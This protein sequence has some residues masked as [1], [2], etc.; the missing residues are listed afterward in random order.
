[1]YCTVLCWLGYDL[2]LELMMERTD[3]PG[4]PPTARTIMYEHCSVPC[5]HPDRFVPNYL[6]SVS[7]N[8]LLCDADS[9]PRV[10]SPA[11]PGSQGE[12]VDRSQTSA[13][14]FQAAFACWRHHSPFP[15]RCCPG[16]VVM[17]SSTI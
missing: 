10:V 4:S 17:D 3:G 6:T 8:T 11:E 16:L 2:P 9:P 1:M 12:T 5:P 13:Q 14:P 7:S 15:P